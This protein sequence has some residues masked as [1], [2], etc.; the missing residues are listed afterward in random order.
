MKSLSQISART[1][2][3]RHEQRPSRG[4]TARVPI[5]S[6]YHPTTDNL[7]GA[8][9]AFRTTPSFRDLSANFLNAEMKR[10]YAAEGVFFAVIVALTGWSSLLLWRAVAA[11]LI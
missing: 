6:D 2:T 7:R 3:T 4:H 9:R 11:L 1:S 5:D 10:E 8:S